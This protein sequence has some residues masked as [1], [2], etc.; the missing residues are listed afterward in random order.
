M[1]SNQSIER[2]SS[3]LNYRP[4]KRNSNLKANSIISH[5]SSASLSNL[6]SIHHNQSTS[7]PSLK[8][9][10]QQRPSSLISLPSD[11]HFNTFK[12]LL[13]HDQNNKS[14]SSSSSNK[15]NPIII[16]FKSGFQPKGVYRNLSNEFINKRKYKQ[17]F[18]RLEESRLQKRLEKL[19]DLHFIKSKKKKEEEEEEKEKEKEEKGGYFNY[20]INHNSNSH[21]IIREKEQMIIRWENDLEGKFCKICKIKFNLLI[22][23]HHCRLCGRIV[24]FLPPNLNH[25]D[26]KREKRCSSLIKFELDHNKKELYPYSGKVI[27]LTEE[28]M[29][30]NYQTNLEF[31]TKKNVLDYMINKHQEKVNGV[32]VCK[33]CLNVILRRQFI[34]YLDELPNYLKLYYKLKSFQDSIKVLFFEFQEMLINSRDQE[35]NSNTKNEFQL[36]NARKR[37]LT[38]LTIYDSIIK[39]LNEEQITNL[40]EIRLKQSII[41]RSNLFL[42]DQMNLIRS[43]GGFDLEKSTKIIS[44]NIKKSSINNHTTSQS[45]NNDKDDLISNSNQD[46]IKLNVLLEQERLIESYLSLAQKSRQ[47]DDV[48]SLKISLDELREE[49]DNLKNCLNG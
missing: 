47:L 14:S 37:L 22:R 33:D 41:T 2:S 13:D 29:G 46:L 20:I 30:L 12:L 28:E 43:I 5:N 15:T 25:Q 23:K 10:D 6:I 24:C 18:K 32:R 19:I 3:P 16:P 34:N 21:Q 31:N 38:N 48:K 4:Y 39:R 27:E 8:L 49:I 44:K 45:I 11:H 35:M 40:S 9:T 42:R 7:N 36:L 1:T 26:I 17:E